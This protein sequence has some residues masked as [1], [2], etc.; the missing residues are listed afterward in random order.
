MRVEAAAAL[1]DDEE[2]GTPG[3]GKLLQ[4]V[5]DEERR[6]YVLQRLWSS[7]RWSLI[8]RQKLCVVILLNRADIHITRKRGLTLRCV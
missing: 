6:R 4:R 3:A 8:L 1:P 2:Q 5:R 7:P